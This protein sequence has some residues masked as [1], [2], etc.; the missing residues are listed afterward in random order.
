MVQF[1]VCRY[2]SF[3][4][5]RKIPSPVRDDSAMQELKESVSQNGVLVPAIARPAQKA[6]MN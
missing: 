2:L 4:R 1:S 6:A 5:T 3:T